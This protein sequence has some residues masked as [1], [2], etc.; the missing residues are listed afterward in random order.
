MVDSTLSRSVLVG[1]V[2]A[3][4]FG[5]LTAASGGIALFGD[6]D[7]G[8]VVPFVLWFNFLAG[9][10]YILAGLGLWLRVR[11]AWWLCAA[12]LAATLI[13]LA[14]FAIHIAQGSAFEPRTVGALLLRSGIWAVIATVAYRAR[15]RD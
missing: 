10:A 14:F 2:V 9:F 11:R 13:V 7:M 6:V 12:I 4:F 1:A 3:I 5:A 8:A 15:P